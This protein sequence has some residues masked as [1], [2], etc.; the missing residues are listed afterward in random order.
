MSR[1]TYALL[2]LLALL[3]LPAQVVAGLPEGA[4]RKTVLDEVEDGLRKYRKEK[5]EE[6]RY[7]LLE[8]LAPTKDARV[9]IAIMEARANNGAHSTDNYRYNLLLAEFFV[10]GTRFQ[11]GNSY[12]LGGW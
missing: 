11:K 1:T 6:K 7:R 4:S 5:D 10:Q 9:A 2:P 8:K 3:V 12:D